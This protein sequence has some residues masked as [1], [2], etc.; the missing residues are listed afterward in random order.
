MKDVMSVAI[1]H[2][3]IVKKHI[4]Q[5]QQLLEH[6]IYPHLLDIIWIDILYQEINLVQEVM[7]NISNLFIELNRI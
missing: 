3:L 5:R 4:R 1:Q 6:N 2:I 7:V